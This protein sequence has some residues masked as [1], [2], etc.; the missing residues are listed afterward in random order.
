M[1]FNDWDVE[2]VYS[3]LKIL[4]VIWMHDQK[5]PLLDS[6]EGQVILSDVMS[7]KRKQEG[8]EVVMEYDLKKQS[9]N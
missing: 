9:S 7:I 2:R 5:I 8:L 3:L 4:Q 6:K 1:N